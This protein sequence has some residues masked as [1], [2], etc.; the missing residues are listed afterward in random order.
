MSMAESMRREWNARAGKDA[1]FYIASWRTDWDAAGFLKSGEEDYQQL[2]APVLDRFAFSPE[3]GTMLELG[4]GAG[5]MTRSFAS[6]FGKV[7]AF[8]V[9]EQMLDRARELLKET[10]NVSFFLGDGL[11]LAA[12]ADESVDFA[13]SYLV[14]QHLPVEELALS[15]IREILRVLR[16]GGLCLFQFNSMTRPTMNWKGRFAWGVIDALWDLRLPKVSRALARLLGFD[17]EMGGKTWHGAAMESARVVETVCAAGGV[18]LDVRGEGTARTWCCARKTETS[19][20]SAS[21][22]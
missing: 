17:P 5:R 8:D 18:V 11:G 7:L 21:S 20:G 10:P 16:P 13:F 15:Y 14:L 4:C 2:V 12:A 19:S 6:R 1:F 3:G 22:D 9:S